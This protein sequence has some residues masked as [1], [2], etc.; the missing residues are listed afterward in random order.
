[1][2]ENEFRELPT[3]SSKESCMVSAVA[4]FLAASLCSRSG[5]G[6]ISEHKSNCL[7]KKEATPTRLG[8]LTDMKGVYAYLKGAN[9]GT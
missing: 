4:S 6:K 9:I 2:K 8:I 7:R 1:M 3:R 5:K